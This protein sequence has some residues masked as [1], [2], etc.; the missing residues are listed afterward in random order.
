MLKKLKNLTI[1]KKAISAFV[2]LKRVVISV[3]VAAV[4]YIIWVDVFA[5]FVLWHKRCVLLARKKES[6][7]FITLISCSFLLFSWLIFFLFLFLPLMW[8]ALLSFFVSLKFFYFYIRVLKHLNSFKLNL[9][10]STG[11]MLAA[12]TFCIHK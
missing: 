5:I 12:G 10:S 4:N 1:L 2:L 3:L 8:A 11:F 7:I 6:A 9:K